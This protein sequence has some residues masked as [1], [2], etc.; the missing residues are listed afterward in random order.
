MRYPG[1]QMWS[2]GIKVSDIRK[3]EHRNTL[4]HPGSGTGKSGVLL[5][6]GSFYDVSMGYGSNLNKMY[7]AIKEVNAEVTL[8][9]KVNLKVEGPLARDIHE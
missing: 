1:S 5:K 6:D 3:F 7:V 2:F 8:P 9:K 4:S